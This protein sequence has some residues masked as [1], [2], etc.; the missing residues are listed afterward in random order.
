VTVGQFH[1]GMQV[2]SSDGVTVGTIK[3]LLYDGTFVHLDCKLAPGMY[4]PVGS[5]ES[6]EG[7]TAVLS[8][9]RLDAGNMGWEIEPKV[10]SPSRE[11]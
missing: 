7:N 3:Q 6:L 11:E 10:G 9:N 8:C 2:R 4:V 5:F 1:P